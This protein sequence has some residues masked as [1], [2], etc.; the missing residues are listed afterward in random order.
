MIEAGTIRA[1]LTLSSSDFNSGLDAALERMRGMSVQSA[2]TAQAASMMGQTMDALSRG[3]LASMMAAMKNSITTSAQMTA[4]IKSDYS[5]AANTVASRTSQLSKQI[6]SALGSVQSQARSAM[7]RAGEGMVSGLGSVQSAILA[8]ARSIASNVAAVMRSALKIASPSKVTRE[9][10][11]HTGMGMALG[12]SDMKNETEKRARD[13]A[14]TAARAMSE[15]GAVSYRAGAKLPYA[16]GIKPISAISSGAA[17]TSGDTERMAR[18]AALHTAAYDTE[19]LSRASFGAETVQHTAVSVH[20]ENLELLAKKLDTLID[21]VSN[22]Q[23]T[24]TVDG[25]SFARLLREYS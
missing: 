16:D 11:E 3:G 18:T 4:A 14:L 5:G 22:S 20:S 2:V 21:R 25:R 23:Q 1:Y 12:L 24:L 6:A 9:I 10:G 19:R 7:V 15:H 17:R 8:K 13:V